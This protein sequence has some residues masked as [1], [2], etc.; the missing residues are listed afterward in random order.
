MKQVKQLFAMMLLTLVLAVSTPAVAQTGGATGGTNYG[1]GTTETED[2]DDGFPWGV[3]GLIGLAGLIPRNKD[4]D[5][6]RR[7]TTTNR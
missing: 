2:D 4:K 7:T 1:T 6:H 5:D 3:L